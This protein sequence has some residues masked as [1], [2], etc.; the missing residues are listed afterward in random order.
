MAAARS[1]IG[2]WST[3]LFPFPSLAHLTAADTRVLGPA[4]GGASDGARW[5]GNAALAELFATLADGV[6]ATV[7]VVALELESADLDQAD[8]ETLICGVETQL[9]REVRAG[10]A[11][12]AAFF[13]DLHQ[14]LCAERA[15]RAT[16]LT[17]LAAA[18]EA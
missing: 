10:H 7:P 2:W 11:T 15:R 5:R 6:R 4:M 18:L 9:A 14:G 16:V 3:M 13:R 8:L 1:R 12:R 17:Q